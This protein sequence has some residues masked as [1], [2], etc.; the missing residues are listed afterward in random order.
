MI[1]RIIIMLLA[2]ISMIIGFSYI[3]IYINLLTFGYTIKEYLLF[4]VQ[5]AECYL[6]VIGLVT[7]IICLYHRKEQK[8]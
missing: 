6:F 3:L 7:E 1:T 8:K 2:F 5:R 4:I